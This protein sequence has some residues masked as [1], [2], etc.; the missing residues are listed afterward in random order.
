MTK[1]IGKTQGEQP[2]QREGELCEAIAGLRSAKEAHRFLLDLC[3]PAELRA[4]ADR[5]KVARLLAQEMPY[6]KIQE[7]TGVSTATVTRVARALV[8]GDGGYRRV[9]EKTSEKTSEKSRA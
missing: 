1:K 2:G 5:W 7:E 4:M 3:T 6:R 8:Y 9:L